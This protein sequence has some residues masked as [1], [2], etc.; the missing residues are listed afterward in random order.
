MDRSNRRDEDYIVTK[1]D[2]ETTPMPEKNTQFTIKRKF[3]DAEINRLKRGYA[4]EEMEE[5]WFYYYEDGKVYFHRSWT[6]S[7]IYIVEFH[8]K[9]NEHIVTVNRDENQYTNTDIDE[10]IETINDLLSI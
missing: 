8:F 10:D 1:A 3:S 5:K 6:G 4:P 9:T 2:W 7:C